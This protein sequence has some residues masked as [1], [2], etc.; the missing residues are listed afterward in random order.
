MV[1][2]TDR[3]CEVR[4][5][6]VGVWQDGSLRLRTGLALRLLNASSRGVLVEGHT[7]LQPGRRLEVHVVTRSGRQP[8]W[9]RVAWVRISLIRPDRV[10]YL[11]GLAFEQTVKGAWREHEL[12]AP[13]ARSG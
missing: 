11:A 9:C 2:S 12:P 4:R 13:A 8:V 5:A 10:E 7:R 3:R 6:V 1:N